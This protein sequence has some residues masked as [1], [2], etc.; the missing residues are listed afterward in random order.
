MTVSLSDRPTDKRQAALNYD[1]D[2]PDRNLPVDYLRACA[3]WFA[4]LS[5]GDRRVAE[6]AIWV[7]ATGNDTSAAKI[8]ADLPAAPAFPL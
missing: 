1:W 5:D 2:D 3:R 8:A 7:Y 6:S 4:G